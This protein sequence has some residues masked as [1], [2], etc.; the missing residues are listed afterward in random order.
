MSRR[1]KTVTWSADPHTIAKIQIVAGYAERWAT[2]LGQGPSGPLTYIDGFAG[3]GEYTNHPIG[4]PIAAIRAILRAKLAV[5]QRWRVTKVH[6]LFIEE[7][8]RRC[9][10]LEKLVQSEVSSAEAQSLVVECLNCAF[11][12]GVW[13]SSSPFTKA[14]T[15]SAPLLAFVDP[16]GAK[17]VSF[18]SVERLL[19]SRTSELIINFSTS[20]FA[21]NYKSGN[22]ALL[23]IAFGTKDWRSRLTPTMS[24]G[25]LCQAALDLYKDQLLAIPNVGYVFAFGMASRS[26][27]PDFFLV[28][29]SQHPRGLVEMKG[30]MRKLDQQGDFQFHDARV[31]Q[32]GLFKFNHPEDW[33][34]VIVNHFLGRTVGLEE[35]ERFILNETPLA[36]FK[37]D[38][39]APAEAE[40]R[41]SVRSKLPRKRGAFNQA[42]MLI[43]FRGYDHA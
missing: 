33:I 12:A 14:L 18:E 3:P 13:R 10:H 28:F 17:D 11:E 4:S 21:R 5:G 41:L 37:K 19:S 22:H 8:R 38:I 30:V 29:A 27:I 16:F 23:D 15:T 39:L 26:S 6:M 35:I 40:G 42:D 31:M 34:P 24:H 36:S 1:P 7:D 9:N 43:E 32:P 2:I 25:Q 20:G